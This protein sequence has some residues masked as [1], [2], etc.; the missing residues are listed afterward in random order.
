[1]MFLF[2][3]QH[4][5]GIIPNKCTPSYLISYSLLQHGQW[6]TPYAICRLCLVLLM[7]GIMMPETCWV[8]NKNV[9]FSASGWLFLHLQN[10]KI[11]CTSQ[12]NSTDSWRFNSTISAHDRQAPDV[13][14]TGQSSPWRELLRC[15][16]VWKTEVI[17]NLLISHFLD[18]TSGYT[19]SYVIKKQ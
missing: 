16:D 9:I 8:T 13:S 11:S 6:C 3:T 4:V 1:M 15:P 17:T 18:Q 14:N 5:S 12:N 2:V 10:A 19:Y 7:M